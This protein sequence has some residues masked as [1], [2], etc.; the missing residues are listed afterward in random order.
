MRTLWNECEENPVHSVLK[1]SQNLAIIN[2]KSS[3]F[4]VGIRFAWRNNGN[5]GQC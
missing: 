2:S 5:C 3:R 1:D 4:Q